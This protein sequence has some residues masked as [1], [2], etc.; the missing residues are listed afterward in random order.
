[1]N[2]KTFDDGCSCNVCPPCNFCINQEPDDEILCIECK[3]PAL[4]KCYS[5]DGRKEVRISG[6]CEKCFDELL[7]E[8]DQ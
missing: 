1:M 2:K 4:E 7:D 6:M 3:E 8:D 5:E